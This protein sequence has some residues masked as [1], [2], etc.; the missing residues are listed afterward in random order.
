MPLSPHTSNRLQPLDVSVFAPFKT[1]L[2]TE[3][4]H[5]LTNH[6]DSRITEYDMTPIIK[7]ALIKSFTPV[8][9]MK[10]FEKTGIY[11]Y[12]PDVFQESDFE[13]AEIILQKG[14]RKDAEKRQ[15]FGQFRLRA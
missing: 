10:G 3:M 9:I 5:W 11:P 4:D 15:S 14:P 8:N 7:S 2:A 1:Y 6:P 12:N 13:V